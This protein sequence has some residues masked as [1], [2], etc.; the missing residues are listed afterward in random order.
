M[1]RELLK[2]VYLRSVGEEKFTDAR[3]HFV[4]SPNL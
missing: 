2:N 4:L 3:K 1:E